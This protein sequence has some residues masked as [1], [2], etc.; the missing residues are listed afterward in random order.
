MWTSREQSSGPIFELERAD[1]A[2]QPIPESSTLTLAAV[3]LSHYP[4]EKNCRKKNQQIDRDERRQRDAD[5]GARFPVGA[6]CGMET[7]FPQF[8]VAIVQRSCAPSLPA[9]FSRGG[10]RHAAM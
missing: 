10:K 6:D 9:A 7:S 5:H 4:E 3:P 8:T 2:T 1:Y